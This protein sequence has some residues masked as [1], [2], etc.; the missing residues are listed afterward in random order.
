MKSSMTSKKYIYTLL[1]ISIFVIQ[2]AVNVMAAEPD[3]TRITAHTYESNVYVTRIY[4][5]ADVKEIAEDSFVNLH[6]LWLIQVDEKNPYYS[7]Y[8]NCLYNKDKTKLLCIPFALTRTQFPDTVTE[9]GTYALKGRCD[10]TRRI[11]DRVI[12]KNKGQLE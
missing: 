6:R 2:M 12:K 9:V 1:L 7:A 8:G 11:V 10:H 5:G 4:I 3:N